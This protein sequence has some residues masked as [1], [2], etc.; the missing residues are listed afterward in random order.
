MKF[1]LFSYPSIRVLFLLGATTAGLS[2]AHQV[3]AAETAA[4]VTTRVPATSEEQFKMM[5]ANKDGKVSPTEHAN[6]AKE[7]FNS[8]DANR[9]GKVTADEMDAVQPKAKPGESRSAPGKLHGMS[10]VD[11]IKVVDANKDGVLT[12]D[13]HSEGSRNMFKELDTDSDG[14]LSLAELRA[15]HERHHAAKTG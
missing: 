6:G 10:S 3:L 12:G 11:K 4:A 14:S 9:D 15:G 13:E 1:P 2:L 8:M 5:D 7:M